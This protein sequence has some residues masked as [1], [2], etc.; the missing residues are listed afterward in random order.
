[1]KSPTRLAASLL[2]VCA[3]ASVASAKDKDKKEAKKRASNIEVLATM[4]LQGKSARNMVLRQNGGNSYLYVQL[5][6]SGGTLVVD[7][8]KP[9]QLKLVSELPG[10]EGGQL[11]VDGNVAMAGGGI[12]DASAAANPSEL[13]LWDVSD[14]KN[15]RVVQRFSGVVRVLRDDRSY[16]YILTRDQLYIVWDKSQPAADDDWW[17]KQSLWG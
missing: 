7:I 14:P 6:D 1:M 12:S 13:V 11:M 17:S 9:T 3:F 5:A 15:P 8:S 4:P 2:L 10:A 16:T